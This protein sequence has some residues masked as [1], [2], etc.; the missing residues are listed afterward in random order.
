M[1][2]N[3]NVF[4]EN[5]LSHGFEGNS[6]APSL[7]AARHYE[8]VIGAFLPEDKN[9]SI[10]EI[11][12]GLGHFALFA[13][14]VKE[15]RNYLGIDISRE[16]VEYVEKH[17]TP[18]VRLV[19]DTVEFL[20]TYRPKADAIILLD[21]I[22]HI[23]KTDQLEFLCGIRDALK[24]GGVL[25]IRTENTVGLTGYYQHTMDYTHEYN[26]SPRSLTQLTRACNLEMKALYGEPYKIRNIRSFFY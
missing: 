17:I 25:I 9:A 19:H 8:R 7:A 22:E 24:P 23:R 10:L 15:Y 6:A 18:N 14:K 1:P 4:F 21:V 20:K 26:F 11:G 5:F 3:K 16:C 2:D 12:V 13:V